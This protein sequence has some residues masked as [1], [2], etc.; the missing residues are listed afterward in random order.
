MKNKTPAGSPDAAS[1][2]TASKPDLRDKVDAAK[3]RLDERTAKARPV[4]SV[5]TLIADHPVASL[6]AGILLGAL[7]AKA[8]PSS[9]RLRKGATGLATVAGKF[10]MDYASK[11]ADAGREGLHKVEDAG[12]AVGDKIVEGSSDAKR[13]AVDLAEVARSAAIEASE[14]AVR[15]VTELASRLKH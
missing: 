5:K 9:G 7:I 1:P 14:I 3:A 15:K 10:A 13:R 2:A 8:L 12:S 6:A 11:A 4:D